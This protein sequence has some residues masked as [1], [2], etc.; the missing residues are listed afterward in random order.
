MPTK[1]AR[2]I[3][4]HLQYYCEAAQTEGVCVYSIP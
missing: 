2:N 3:E 1:A 4:L